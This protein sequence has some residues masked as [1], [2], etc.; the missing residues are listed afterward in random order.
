MK[1]LRAIGYAVLTAI[2][3]AW[4]LCTIAWMGMRETYWAA[5][6]HSAISTVLVSFGFT[7]GGLSVWLILKLT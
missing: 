7:L 6:E 1:P 4:I 3:M 5:R 2:V